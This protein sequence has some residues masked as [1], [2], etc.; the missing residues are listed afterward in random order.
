MNAKIEQTTLKC[1]CGRTHIVPA[2]I[3][4]KSKD[5]LERENFEMR[6]RLTAL[7]AILLRL[8]TGTVQ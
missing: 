4:T 3:L 2:N 7:K 5:E 1:D 6:A 8:S